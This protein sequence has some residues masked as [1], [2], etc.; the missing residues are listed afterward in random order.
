ME[1]QKAGQEEGPEAGVARSWQGGQAEDLRTL[2]PEPGRERIGPQTADW[3]RADTA[4]SFSL[5][6]SPL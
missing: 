1:V 6:S 5:S 2:L 3:R 4:L